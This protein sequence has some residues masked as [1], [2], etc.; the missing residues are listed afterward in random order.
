MKSKKLLKIKN[1]SK[2]DYKSKILEFIVFEKLI[3]I[4]VESNW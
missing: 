4:I 1:S 2:T 3:D